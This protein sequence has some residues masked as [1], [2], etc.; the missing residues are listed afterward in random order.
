MSAERENS[1][2]WDRV[3]DEI[4]PSVGSVFKIQGDPNFYK[5]GPK[6]VEYAFPIPLRLSLILFWTLSLQRYYRIK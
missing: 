5:M 1:K 6:G 2:L 4:V 3:M